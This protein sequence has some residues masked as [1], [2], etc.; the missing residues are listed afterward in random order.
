MSRDSFA[1]IDEKEAAP[2]CIGLV[3]AN[4][5]KDAKSDKPKRPS[6][7]P[8]DHVIKSL[9][10]F[11]RAYSLVRVTHHHRGI[12]LA[13]C[14]YVLAEA[15]SDLLDEIASEM[16]E[17]NFYGKNNIWTRTPLVPLCFAGILV[18]VSLQAFPNN[19]ELTNFI[20][21]KELPW[22]PNFFIEGD[23][24]KRFPELMKYVAFKS[25]IADRS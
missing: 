18:P 25:A 1:C 15:S 12:K 13:I 9:G 17:G 20:L 21:G 24:A 19:E 14:E 4:N 16:D 10:E 6:L 11:K 22:C 3:P 5:E 7:A 23:V 8:G 2:T